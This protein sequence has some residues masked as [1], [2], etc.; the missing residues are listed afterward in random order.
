MKSDIDLLKQVFD[1]LDRKK[2]KTDIEISKILNTSNLDELIKTLLFG[3]SK[4]I[5]AYEKPNKWKLCRKIDVDVF[6]RFCNFFTSDIEVPEKT[7][8]RYY[9][10]RQNK[11]TL[12]NPHRIIKKTTRK[13]KT[14]SIRDIE[15][16]LVD[17][18]SEDYSNMMRIRNDGFHYGRKKQYNGPED[19]PWL[20][21]NYE[22]REWD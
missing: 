10:F 2:W 1:V 11:T 4:D 22:K 20:D 21:P 15:K 9:I 16:T 12:Q 14:R 3:N 6:K 7:L 18:Q 17:Y 19:L 5:F 8:R 13:N